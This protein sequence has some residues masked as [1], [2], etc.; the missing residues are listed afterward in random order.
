LNAGL[1]VTDVSYLQL[2][3]EERFAMV[4]PEETAALLRTALA[5]R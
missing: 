2:L 3:L 4:R 1:H 5:A